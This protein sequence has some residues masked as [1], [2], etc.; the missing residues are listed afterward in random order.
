LVKEMC[1]ADAVAAIARATEF[2]R[3]LYRQQG[4]VT[5]LADT[6][7]LDILTDT[8]ERSPTFSLPPFRRNDDLVSPPSWAFVKN[9]LLATEEA[10]HEMLQRPPRGLPWDG[11]T[12]RRLNAPDVL[13]Q[14]PPRLDTAEI[15]KFEIGS[16]PDPARWAAA[17][18]ALVV[19]LV[20]REAVQLTATEHPFHA[21]FESWSAKFTQTTA[22][23]VGPHGGPAGVD[24]LFHVPCSLPG[25]PLVLW[26]HLAVKLALNTLST[27]T[28]ALMGRVVGNW[29]VHV[30]ASNKK[31]IDRSTRL[32]AGLTGLDYEEACV[33]LYE[34]MDEIAGY[35][36][37]RE[38]PSPAA[39]A[40][41]RIGR[42]TKE[43]S[44]WKA[45]I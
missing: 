35:E 30:Q 12:Y 13:Q 17:Q 2:E 23:C 36:P 20:G 5:Y 24:A 27:A 34:A 33:A 32:I 3:D 38:R 6:F 18:T 29:M 44:K 45:S 40:V 14:N 22:I 25:S 7:L 1:S 42:R 41:E 26:E 28:M 15:V 21:A 4:L 9:P 39:L 11:A 10:W 16:E 31:L 43:A 37:G 8:T 19:V